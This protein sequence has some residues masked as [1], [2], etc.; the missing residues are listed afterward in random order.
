MQVY[1]WCLDGLSR[2]RRRSVGARR[3]AL[4]E[5]G[6][7]ACVPGEGRPALELRAGLGESPELGEEAAPHAR[8]EVIARARRLP[9]EGIDELEARRGPERHS[10]SDRSTQ[11]HDA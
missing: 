11:L 2:L 5:Q 8:Q 7:L 1:S 10:H 9:W 3:G 4:E 6:S